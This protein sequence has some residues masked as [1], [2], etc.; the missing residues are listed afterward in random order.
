MDFKK[1]DNCK[2]YNYS[3]DNKLFPCERFGHF[4]EIVFKTINAVF[5]LDMN[6]KC[7]IKNIHYSVYKIDIYLREEENASQRLLII[8]TL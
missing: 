4:V 8:E 6:K 1:V 5:N 2:Y 3:V 7:I